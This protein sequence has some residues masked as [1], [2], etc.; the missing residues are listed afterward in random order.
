MFKILTASLL[1]L[2]QSLTGSPSDP[3]SL[4]VPAPFIAGDPTPNFF[5]DW[6]NPVGKRQVPCALVPGQTTETWIV[7]LP[8][9]SNTTNVTP[10][11]YAPTNPGVQNFNISDGNC[12]VPAVSGGPIDPMLGCTGY[13]PN[14][15]NP[16]PNGNWA[17]ILA[18]IRINAGKAQREVM[19]TTGVGGSYMHD[20]EPGGSDNVR[21]GVTARRLDAAGLTPTGIL[22]GQGESD[23]NTTYASYLASLQNVIAD[24]R[25]HWPTTPIYV[26][27]E[28]YINGFTSAAV[29][30][31][32]AA[33]VNPANHVF[34]GPNLDLRGAPY[35]QSDDTHFNSSPGAPT[36][37]SDWNA[38][39]P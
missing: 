23:L 9:Q 25:T 16:W 10:T 17:G 15:P 21:I 24:I 19:V 4:A 38:T 20:W 28:T 33:V 6:N 30:S 31:A 32:Q 34:A 14:L 8:G 2:I 11:L 26:A 36:V 35:R 13:A 39:L 18:D 1:L 27:Q 12:Y 29:R 7:G 22:I 3:N 37:A 5:P